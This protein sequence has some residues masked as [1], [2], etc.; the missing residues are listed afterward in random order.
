M[1][2]PPRL[3]RL[4]GRHDG[5][6]GEEVVLVLVLLPVAAHTGAD[7]GLAWWG[8]GGARSPAGLGGGAEEGASVLLFISSARHVLNKI[9]KNEIIKRMIFSK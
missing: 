7:A 3:G 1:A 2:V 9:T 5:A 4:V 6:G 8:V